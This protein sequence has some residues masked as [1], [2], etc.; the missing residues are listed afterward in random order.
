MKFGQNRASKWPTYNPPPHTHTLE[1][2]ETKT[3]TLECKGKV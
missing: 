2:K 3:S 1:S